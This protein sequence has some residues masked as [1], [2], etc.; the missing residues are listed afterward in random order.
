MF[1]EFSKK[2]HGAGFVNHKCDADWAYCE[3]LRAG[4][5]GLRPKYHQRKTA[6]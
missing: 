3:T 5:V 6:P 1:L 2:P 4:G